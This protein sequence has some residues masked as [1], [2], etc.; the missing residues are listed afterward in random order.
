MTE[1]DTER[2]PD[3]HRWHLVA[4]FA[5]IVLALLALCGLLL[6]HCARI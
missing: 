5:P 3:P 1:G 2:G 6:Y 4:A